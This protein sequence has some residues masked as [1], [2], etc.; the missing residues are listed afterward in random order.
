MPGVRSLQALA[1]R[2]IPREQYHNVRKSDT[3]Q[4]FVL[5]SVRS[6][7]T[8]NYRTFAEWAKSFRIS[9]YNRNLLILLNHYSKADLFDAINKVSQHNEEGHVKDINATYWFYIVDTLQDKILVT[10]KADDDKQERI[11]RLYRWP[12]VLQKTFYCLCYKRLKGISNIKETDIYDPNHPDIFMGAELFEAI[13]SLPESEILHLIIYD[14][15]DKYSK[16]KNYTYPTL[17]KVKSDI[18]SHQITEKKMMNSFHIPT[19]IQNLLTLFNHHSN[20]DF[21]NAYNKISIHNRGKAHDLKHINDDYWDD[22]IS[23]LD[24]KILED[25]VLSEE[26]QEELYVSERWPKILQKTFYCLCFKRLKKM[27]DIKVTDI[28]APRK[29]DIFMDASLFV[30]I[31]SLPESET[32]H[33]IIYNMINEHSKNQSSS[34]PRLSAS[35]SSS[36]SQSSPHSSSQSSPHSS[37]KSSHRSSSKSSPRS[38]SKSSPRS[39]SHPRPTSSSSPNIRPKKQIKF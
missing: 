21:F 7:V 37:S 25:H 35:R 23:D 31:M 19:Y 27:A 5:Q 28:Y 34:V 39:T 22:I 38:S 6:D 29:H 12:K 9:P 11:Y 3:P 13:K 16:T 24:D 4:S 20:A 17:K 18:S 10:P 1:Y 26:D 14:M 36:S 32:L 2:A 15:I 30:K 8:S 33:F